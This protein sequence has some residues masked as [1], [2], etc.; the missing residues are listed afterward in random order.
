[1]RRLM[2]R[3]SLTALF[4]FLAL[5]V[6]ALAQAYDVLVL[7]SRRAQAFDDVRNGFAKLSG[8]KRI[9]VMSDYGDVDIIRIIREDQPRLILAI[10]DEAL[11]AARKIRNT[12]VVAVLTLRIGS[13]GALP[14]NLSGIS[15]FVSPERY[16]SLFRSMNAR[17]VGIIHNRAK[18]GWY[19][20][21]ARQTAKEAGIE[22]VVREVSSPRETVDT[23]SRLSGQVDALWMLPDAT[24]VTSETTEAFFLFGQ[25]HSVPVVAF[26]SMYL[27]M[28]AA[29]VLDIDRKELGRQAAEMARKILD[30]APIAEVSYPSGIKLKTNVTVLKRLNLS[31]DLSTTR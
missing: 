20:A 21:E 25:N 19:L 30:G 12:P 23:L 18:C 29:A 14:R 7:Q 31:G 17:R 9:I 5:L 1:M 16:I 8:S 4:L 22:L 26:S 10:G 11:A 3:H 27:N 2:H 24:T 13:P 28:G 6:P 15:M